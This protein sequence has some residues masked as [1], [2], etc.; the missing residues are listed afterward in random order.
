MHTHTHTHIIN[1]HPRLL[2]SI[3]SQRV[4]K[5][6]RRGEEKHQCEKDISIFASHTPHTP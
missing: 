6:I 1:P 4:W 2:F 5:G 3:D